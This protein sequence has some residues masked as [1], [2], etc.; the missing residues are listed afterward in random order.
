MEINLEKVCSPCQIKKQI[1]MSH[2]MMQHPSTTRVLKLLYTDLMRPIKFRG[3]KVFVD[4]YLGF[5]WV[6]FL[7]EKSDTLNAFKILFLKLMREK[8]RQFKKAIRLRSDHGK[9]FENSH[10]TKFCNKH[11]ID[12]EF[13]TPKTPQQNRV[14]EGKNKALR[15]MTRIMLKAKNVPV[16]F[17]AEALNTTCYDLNRVY[18]CL[19]ITMTPFEIWRG[20]KPNLKYF[21]EFG[22]TYFI[23]NDMEQRSKFDVKRDEGIFLGYSLNSLAYGVYNKRTNVIMQYVNVDDHGSKSTLTRS[24]NSDIELCILNRYNKTVTVS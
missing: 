15:E 20:K 23:L 11:G 12:H 16:E 7:I 21:H 24:D 14:E 4:D 5:S 22:S 6:S 17:W 10:F 8:N 3:E 9:K 18:H 13:S 19:R 1:Q 2:K